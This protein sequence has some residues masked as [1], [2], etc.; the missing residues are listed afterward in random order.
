MI[1]PKGKK[2]MK[3]GIDD[4]PRYFTRLIIPSVKNLKIDLWSDSVGEE[5]E[6][7]ITYFGPITTCVNPS[8]PVEE[9]RT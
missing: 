8:W 2:S 1:I 3:V 9:W 5:I 6:V 4:H 7:L